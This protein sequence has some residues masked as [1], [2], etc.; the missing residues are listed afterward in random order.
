[1]G[2]KAGKRRRFGIA[3]RLTA[4]FA[5]LAALAAATGAASSW[6]SMQ[7]AKIVTSLGSHVL[8]TVTSSMTFGEQ[9][10]VLVAE[11]PELAS[12]PTAEAL[13]EKAGRIEGVMDAQ[14]GRLA[15][16]RGMVDTPALLNE[17]ERLNAA[18]KPK[19]V[20][21]KALAAERIATRAK[22]QDLV[23]KAL[24][25]YQ[26][27]MDAA[28]PLQ[29]A[30][31]TA[32]DGE[33]GTVKAG[34]G[35]PA[36]IAAAAATLAKDLAT[37]QA[38][39][40][41]Q[42]T[43]NLAFGMMTAA[44]NATEDASSGIWSQYQ[45]AEI[46][47]RK[48]LG[49]FGSSDDGKQ[50]A[51]LVD[52]LL[53][54]GSD[55]T[56]VFSLRTHELEL[57][58]KVAGVLADLTTVSKELAR[59]VSALVERQDGAARGAAD[60]SAEM[61]RTTL[62]VNAVASGIVIVAALLIGILYVRR[63]LVR[64]LNTLGST[65]DRLA[66][67]DRTVTVAVNGRDEITDMAAAVQVFR[68]NMV[69]NEELAA[70][71][72][73]LGAEQEASRAA[74][75]AERGEASARQASVVEGLAAGLAQLADGNLTVDLAKPF[76]TEYESLRH[77]FNAALGQLR[78][79]VTEVVENAEGLRTGTNEIAGA[80]DDLS[81]RTENQAA[82]LEETAAALGEVTGALRKTAEGAA[83]ARDVVGLA[84]S[85]AEQSGTVMRDA[86]AAMGAIETSSDK[87]GQIISVVDEIA[88]QTNLLA[89]N[90]GVEAARA[91]EAGRGF[92]V[93]ASEVRALA[94]RSAEA[95]KEI[96]ALVS[97]SRTQVSRGVSLVGQGGE[98][99]GRV[100]GEVSEINTIVTEIARAATE[101][102]QGL[103]QVNVAVTQMDQ[104]TQ[105]N[106]A[107]VEQTTAASH[108][109][110][111]EI[112]ALVTMMGRFRIGAP[113]AG[114]P[115]AA[116]RPAMSRHSG[117]PALARKRDAVPEKEAWADF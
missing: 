32:V 31:Q 71:A 2:L 64:R 117:G 86:V 114:R 61:T 48:A 42:A 115:Q 107:M 56:S 100:L 81:R 77:D 9:S 59:N 96:K 92:A 68:Q 7:S 10:A 97:S 87:I 27:L 5:G 12:Q 51:P 85:Q 83:H 105:Q 90:A 65:M 23:A 84:K 69:R 22:I 47:I 36:E 95:A 3:A 106:A 35:T 78:A 19:I 116:V 11:A 111:E 37:L 18:L 8:P 60:R 30:T 50:L 20:E 54:G 94:Q 34:Q 73:R 26:D 74:A 80:A 79:T 52:A 29:M 113:A 88:F 58:G 14:A 45:W 15:A 39:S 99:L 4:A 21:L 75:E 43:A 40:D 91:G 70:E 104:V 28:R 112:E 66:R 33:I 13:A 93:V 1:M 41:L 44:A 108:H 16:L 17:V 62:A 57:T 103:E 82:S 101:Q 24:T 53:S 49:V 109:L 89:L 98:A 38:A 46:Y 67:G 55:A 25:R 6:F 72:A 102:M 76:A 110:A 63:S